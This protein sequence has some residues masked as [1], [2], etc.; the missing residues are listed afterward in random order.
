[1]AE[2]QLNRD[3]SSDYLESSFREKLLEHVFISEILQEAWLGRNKTVE[4]LRSE[5]DSAGYD[6]LLECGGT[7]RY[8]QLKGSKAGAKT[9]RQTVNA[10]LEDKPGGCVIWLIYQVADHRMTLEYLVRGGEPGSK[11]YLACKRGKQTRANALGVKAERENT[12]VLNKGE[13]KKITST[14]DLFDFLFGGYAIH[15]TD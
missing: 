4:V 11:P 15:R 12:R 10:R 13:F 7:V 14:H 1:M 3:K 5:V 2:L 9:S 8:I 6:L